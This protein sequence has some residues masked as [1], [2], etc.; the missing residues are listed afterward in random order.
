MSGKN[1][2]PPLIEF[3]NI[4]VNRGL[5]PALQDFSLSI[6]LGE[7]VAVLG[8]N[9]SGK[10]TLIKTMTR[11]CYPAL[12]PDAS[13]RIL[14]EEVWELFA[15]RSMLGIVSNDLLEECTWDIPGREM[16]LSGFF[17]SVG[18]W[19][20]HH[21]TPAM[22]ARAD[23]LLGLLGIAHLAERSIH[24]MSAGEVQRALVGRALVEHP[25]ALVLDEPTNSLDVRARHELNDTLRALAARGTT[26]VTVTHNLADVIPEIRRVV[27]LKRGKV[28]A[29]G[30]K[31][32]VLRDDLLSRLFDTPVE[33]T[34]R[35]GYY[36]L[37]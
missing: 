33:V 36:H 4:T 27:L 25:K 17:S 12:T 8:P 9:G 18:I 37:W 23:E 26:I 21:V 29:D 2:A 34:R 35:D 30:P 11:E 31:E 16:I 1:P 13:V 14:G 15:L 19:P 7:H 5:R 32:E 6:P 20:N 24:Q 3:R 28:F 22:E 10:S